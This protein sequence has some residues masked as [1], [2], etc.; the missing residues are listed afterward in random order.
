MVY[1]S[2]PRRGGGRTKPLILNDPPPGYRPPKR[3]AWYLLVG[4]GQARVLVR[5]TAVIL[6]LLAGALAVMIALMVAGHS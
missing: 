4:E 5:V 3:S 1:L 6:V 2:G